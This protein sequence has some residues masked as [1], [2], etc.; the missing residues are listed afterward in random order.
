M[1]VQPLV[2]RLLQLAN[3][4][5]L[6]PGPLAH[7]LVRP[8][9]VSGVS[10]VSPMAGRDKKQPL[11]AREAA[12]DGQREANVG[13]YTASSVED[14]RFVIERQNDQILKQNEEIKTLKK[15]ID[16]NDKVV[17]DFK[18]ELSEVRKKW[19]SMGDLRAPPR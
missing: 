9:G 2:S 12:N 10:G 4:V 3:D 7:K 17:S 14:L 19:Q 11:K 8:S 13:L 1:C 6:N 18:S 15:K 5:E 16:D